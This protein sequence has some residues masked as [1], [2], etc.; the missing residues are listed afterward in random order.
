MEKESTKKEFNMPVTMDI[1]TKR[2]DD[3]S[4]IDYKEHLRQ[5]KSWIKHKKQGEIYYLSSQIFY[6]PEDKL[7][8]FGMRETFNPFRGS[9]KKDLLTPVLWKQDTEIQEAEV[10]ENESN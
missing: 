9:V 4:F 7:K 1:L 5:Q 6:A 2:P 10:V 8:M 3:M